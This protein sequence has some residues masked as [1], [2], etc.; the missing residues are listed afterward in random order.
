M[1]GLQN[2]YTMIKVNADIS[3]I[4]SIRF[5][6]FVD[7]FSFLTSVF[8]DISSQVVGSLQILLQFSNLTWWIWILCLSHRSD[9]CICCWK[10]CELETSTRSS[11][12]T[13]FVNERCWKASDVRHQLNNFQVV[14][15]VSFNYAPDWRL[16]FVETVI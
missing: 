13:C 1:H 10:S 2:L 4:W 9:T 12:F 7:I 15:C 11:F 16:N 8:V 6:I 3:E 5:L 14:V